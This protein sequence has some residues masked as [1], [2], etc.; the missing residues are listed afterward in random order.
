MRQLP[1]PFA[2]LCARSDLR[3]RM[4]KSVPAGHIQLHQMRPLPMAARTMTTANRTSPGVKSV[5]A[6][7]KIEYGPTIQA[8]APKP[9]ATI[10]AK[11]ART[12][13]RTV[14][15]AF[16]SGSLVQT[17]RTWLRGWNSQFTRL[18]AR[19]S[20]HRHSQNSLP[21]TGVS[22]RT[23]RNVIVGAGCTLHAS[24]V[25]NPKKAAVTAAATATATSLLV[26][27]FSA[28]ISNPPSC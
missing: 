7:P 20:G 4:L 1:H 15:C 24:S 9:V 3:E 8:T 26:Q 11:S 2:T 17:R 19:P 13:Q 23:T 27:V 22:S 28:S 18:C 25:G 14:C 21:T 12:V 16:D 5:R 10:T 6:F